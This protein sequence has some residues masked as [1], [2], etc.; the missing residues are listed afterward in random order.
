HVSAATTQALSEPSSVEGPAFLL[1]HRAGPRER[2]RA[3]AALIVSLLVFAALAPFAQVQLA[4]VP[5][6]IPIY[7]SALVILDL[8]TAVL[9]FGQYRIARTDA[10]LV[11]GAGYL[12]TALMAVGHALTFPG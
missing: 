6:F 5:A 2:R 4:P 7:E 3:L 9:L 10:L 1:T 11:L 8:M 12:F